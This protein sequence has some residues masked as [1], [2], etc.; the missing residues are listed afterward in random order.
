MKLRCL[1]SFAVSEIVLPLILVLENFSEP[2]VEC[3]F[4]ELFGVKW[5]PKLPAMKSIKNSLTRIQDDASSPLVSN[6][7]YV[8]KILP[9]L[10]T[11]ILTR[12]YEVRIICLHLIP[13]YYFIGLKSSYIHQLFSWDPYF[14]PL[15]F[16]EV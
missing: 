16:K 10:E 1:S 6:E 5:D 13:W 14:V 2:G 4:K 9:F 3:F 11:A 7:V 8:K 12:R 15:F